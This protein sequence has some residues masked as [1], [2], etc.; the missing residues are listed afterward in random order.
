M[1]RPTPDTALFLDS[2]P[3]NPIPFYRAAE[4]YL[5]ELQKA[6]VTAPDDKLKRI[7]WIPVYIGK[8]Q[9]ARIDLAETAG[10]YEG[11]AREGLGQH[12]DAVEPVVES[13]L[14]HRTIAPSFGNAL[15]NAVWG[16]E[17]VLDMSE[18]WKRLRNSYQP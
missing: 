2:L 1:S 9:L 10:T 16:T 6:G 11:G 17:G 5:E 12:L 13:C 18:E 3:V 15:I 7:L 14:K 8:G 4:E